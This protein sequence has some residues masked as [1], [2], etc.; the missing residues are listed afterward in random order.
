MSTNANIL[1]TIRSFQHEDFNISINKETQISQLKDEIYNKTQILPENQRLIYRAKRLKNDL[2]LSHYITNDSALVHLVAG[3]SSNPIMSISENNNQSTNNVE[4]EGNNQNEES[5]LSNFIR[6]IFGNRANAPLRNS[7]TGNTEVTNNN[8][9]TNDFQTNLQTRS[10]DRQPQVI[11]NIEVISP[12]FIQGRFPNY[13]NFRRDRPNV[14]RSN[15]LNNLAENAINRDLQS[16]SRNVVQNLRDQ[17][18]NLEDMLLT[19]RDNTRRIRT[20]NSDSFAQDFNLQTTEGNRIITSFEQNL[21][22]LIRYVQNSIELLNPWIRRLQN[23]LQRAD[24]YSIQ[25]MENLAFI[26]NEVG[27]IMFSLQDII[28]S[29]SRYFLE[30]NELVQPQVSAHQNQAI[31]QHSEPQNPNPRNLLSDQFDRPSQQPFFQRT[32]SAD[33][34]MGPRFELQP[35]SGSIYFPTNLLDLGGF[36][37]E[38]HNDAQNRS[39][40]NTS[41]NFIPNISNIQQQ[42]NQSTINQILTDIDNLLPSLSLGPE[43]TTNISNHQVSDIRSM[44]SSTHPQEFL[45][46]S[47]QPLLETMNLGN[48]SYGNSGI[49]NPNSRNQPMEIIVEIET[50]DN[51]QNYQNSRQT[52]EQNITER[53]EQNIDERCPSQIKIKEQLTNETLDKGLFLILIQE[54]TQKELDDLV[55]IKLDKQNFEYLWA[56]QQ[57]EQTTDQNFSPYD[58]LTL[59]SKIEKGFYSIRQLDCLKVIDNTILNC[60][61][62]QFRGVMTLFK[63]NQKYKTDIDEQIKE[64]YWLVFD[65]QFYSIFVS[66]DVFLEALENFLHKILKLIFEKVEGINFQAFRIILKDNIEAFLSKICEGGD[67]TKFAGLFSE[68]L[69]NLLLKYSSK[70]FP[71]IVDKNRLQPT[72]SEDY[73]NNHNNDSMMI[74]EKK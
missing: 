53:S 31:Q 8:S 2:K 59:L 13:L 49:L 18:F 72:I 62:I 15:S 33:T 38:S 19:N 67:I 46:Q 12:I 22:R 37:N 24:N 27:H 25:E 57:F 63:Y 40:S 5:G 68:F 20:N 55:T 47:G 69:S 66:R 42:P 7:S 30:Y 41:Q 51:E 44:N 70:H 56:K 1:I 61:P 35:N 54:L 9:N 71:Q 43:S 45:S 58:Y 39:N 50:R 34:P 4:A 17:H 21:G 6:N 16:P 36:G 52:G 32:N 26:A 65:K 29:C 64:F 48:D 73:V 23:D 28:Q 60:Y 14:A 74:E 10:G 11:G 3:R